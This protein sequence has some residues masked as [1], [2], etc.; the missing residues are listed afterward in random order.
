MRSSHWDIPAELP[1]GADGWPTRD[2]NEFKRDAGQAWWEGLMA[3]RWFLYESETYPPLIDRITL[4][5]G[6][7]HKARWTVTVQA[8]VGVVRLLSFHG[9]ATVVHAL[10]NLLM[11][12]C[13]S[14]LHW[15]VAG[16]TYGGRVQALAANN[17]T[18]EGL[19][20]LIKEA[21]AAAYERKKSP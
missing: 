18:P 4:T 16:T 12:I 13:R 5:H 15:R 14:N 20:R 10:A 7:G 3:L 21:V 8:H 9:G 2:L 6:Q 11:A 19:E 1:D 17:L